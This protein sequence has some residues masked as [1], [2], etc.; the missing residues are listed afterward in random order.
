[1]ERDMGGGGSGGRSY[2]SGRNQGNMGSQGNQGNMARGNVFLSSGPSNPTPSLFGDLNQDQSNT[3]SRQPS[4][5]VT[6]RAG[7]NN[8]SKQ[9]IC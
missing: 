1:M 9:R 4:R 3:S 2:D 6:G 7:R 5:G 8:N